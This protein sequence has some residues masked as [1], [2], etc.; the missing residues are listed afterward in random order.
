MAVIKQKIVPHL[1]FDSEAK[2]AANFYCSVFPDSSVTNLTTLHGTP[3]GDCD[4]VSFTLW[5]CSFMAISAGAV[6]TFNPSVSFIVNFD[7]AQDKDAETRIDEVWEKLSE[8]GEVLMPL[9]TYPFSERY[10]WIQDKYGLSWQLIL[11]NPEG[12]E[13][14]LIIPSLMFVGELCGK[15]EEASAFYLSVFKNARRGELVRYPAGMEPDREGTVMFTDFMLERQW[16]AAMDSAHEHDF[17]FNEAISFLVHCEDQNEIDDYW[18]KLS[19]VP[20]A[21][22]CG[23]LKDPYGL[24]WQIVPAVMESMMQDQDAERLGRVA[25]EFFKMRKLDLAAL[26]RAYDGK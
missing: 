5:G 4:I 17:A 15:A 6:F 10:G 23:W 21:E 13:R 24:S 26:Q 9:D 1:W 7:P 3:S 25:Q 2:E 12:E 22:Q 16:F 19:A 11:T 20:E 14:P 8:N 18:E